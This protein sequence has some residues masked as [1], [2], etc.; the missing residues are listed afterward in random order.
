MSKPFLKHNKM[1]SKKQLDHLQFC[2]RS[3]LRGIN[4]SKN[5]WTPTG[6]ASHL[7]SGDKASVPPVFFFSTWKSH[8]LPWKFLPMHSV[9]NQSVREKISKRTR[10][11]TKVCVKFLR[12]NYTWKIEFYAWKKTEFA[13]VKTNK[14]PWKVFEKSLN[15]LFF[16][17]I[18]QFCVYFF[19]Y[20]VVFQFLI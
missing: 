18:F 6:Y 1:E 2:F 8:C 12:K 20:L 10:E 4:K 7:R 3:S 16:G 13:C 9:K 14:C 11:N 5:N 17:V 15:V 19:W